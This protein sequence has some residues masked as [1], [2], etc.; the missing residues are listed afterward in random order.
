[1][2]SSGFQFHILFFLALALY[3]AFCCWHV[4]CHAL[5]NIKIVQVPNGPF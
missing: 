3:F 5:P 2:D 1:M 4:G